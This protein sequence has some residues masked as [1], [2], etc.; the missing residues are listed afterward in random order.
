M[1]YVHAAAPATLP[2]KSCPI[3]DIASPNFDPLD[4]DLDD[5]PPLLITERRLIRLV[6]VAVETAAR[7]ERE[8][9]KDDPVVWLVKPAQVFDGARPIDACQQQKHLVRA[10][11]LHRLS[12]G[13]DAPGDFI[14]SLAS[15]DEI[16]DVET[17]AGLWATPQ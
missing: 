7:F 13:L 8:G 14:G 12:L 10:I 5:D 4:P 9:I 2:A 3:V 11:I 15:E 1:T 16:A 6:T 17:S